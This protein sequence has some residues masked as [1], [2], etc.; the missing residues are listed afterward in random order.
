VEKLNK[1]KLIDVDNIFEKFM[2]IYPF[3]LLIETKVI[4]NFFNILLLLLTI[5]KVKKDGFKKSFLEKWIF[6][7]LIGIIISFINT[8]YEIKDGVH[9]L[10]RI[11]RWIF[12]PLILGQF[13]IS[14]KVKRTMLYSAGAAIFVYGI[15]FGLNVIGVN[16]SRYGNRYA[17]GDVIAQISLILGI[18]LIVGLILLVYKKLPRK[19]KFLLII[20]NLISLI[21]LILTQTRGMYL[22][23]ILVIPLILFIKNIKHFIMISIFGILIAS[24]LLVTMPN[25][26]IIIT[27]SIYR[28]FSKYSIGFFPYFYSS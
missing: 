14:Q 8:P 3:L 23:M 22:S 9:Q 4:L 12:F 1:V 6:L 24:I 17:G 26:K 18:C 20:V 10:G 25:N 13:N 11:L 19:E 16:P 7:F 27:D 21:L 5:I 15:K 2:I 28:I